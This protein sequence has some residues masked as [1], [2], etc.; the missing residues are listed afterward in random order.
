[1]LFFDYHADDADGQDTIEA[2]EQKK[3]VLDFLSDNFSIIK[4][5]L[6]YENTMDITIARKN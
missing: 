4:G 3:D 5:S 6:D 2:V 1:M